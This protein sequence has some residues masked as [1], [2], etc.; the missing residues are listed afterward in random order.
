MNKTNIPN[1]F[2]YLLLNLIYPTDKKYSKIIS[3]SISFVGSLNH[4][5]TLFCF[6]IS[7]FSIAVLSKTPKTVNFSPT[8]TNHNYW[9]YARI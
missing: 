9:R 1:G 3:Y 8:I 5:L 7:R 2:T 6:V 4:L